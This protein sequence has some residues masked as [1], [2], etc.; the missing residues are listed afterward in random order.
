MIT[1]TKCCCSHHSATDG[2]CRSY[3]SRIRTQTESQVSVGNERNLGRS[4]LSSTQLHPQTHAFSLVPPAAALH[5][6]STS[7]PSDSMTFFF[8]TVCISLST[9]RVRGYRETRQSPFHD[10]VDACDCDR[11]LWLLEVRRRLNYF[12]ARPSAVLGTL[13]HMGRV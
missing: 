7:T 12:F 4:L 10:F 11:S 2:I 8:A 3:A 9:N 5:H 13:G 1:K 6:Q